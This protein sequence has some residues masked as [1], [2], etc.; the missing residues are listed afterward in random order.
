M[1]STL[2]NQLIIL[3]W[4]H[5]LII[6]NFGRGCRLY[7]RNRIEKDVYN[8]SKQIP[9]NLQSEFP[10]SNLTPPPRKTSSLVYSGELSLAEFHHPQ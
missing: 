1:K 8:D 5:P 7:L 9:K 2:W 3:N 10:P 4:N 6:L